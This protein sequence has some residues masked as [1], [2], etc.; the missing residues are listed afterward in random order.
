MSCD[1]LDSAVFYEVYPTSFY[2]SDADGI[3]DIPGII[4][5]LPYIAQLGCTAIWLNPC[6]CS[7]F[8]DGGYDITDY[9]RVDPRFGTNEDLK[10]LFDAARA[11]GIRVLLDLVMGH[12]SDRH[13]WFLESCKDEQN[14]FT[15]AYI[16]ADH[17]D[18]EHGAPQFL[19]GLSERPHMYKVNYFASQPALNYGYYRPKAAWQSAMDSPAALQNRRRLID[20]C[21]FW[22]EMG[23]AGFRLPAVPAF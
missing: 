4:E 20:V 2:D 5:K 13:P 3:G 23:A 6:F 10:R 17:L 1:W 12:T 9:Y 7:P 19:G 15:Q 14:E 16:W 22:L 21:C 8:R 11:N 18:A